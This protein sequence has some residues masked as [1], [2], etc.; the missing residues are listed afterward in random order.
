MNRANLT[1]HVTP[2]VMAYYTF[3]QGFRPGGFNRTDTSPGQ[4]PVQRAPY[5]G[6]ASSDPRCGSSGDLYH[7]DTFQYL[8]PVSWDSDKL[9]NNELGIKSEF[10]AHRVVLNASAFRMSWNNVQWSL[11]DQV[12][13]GSLGFVANGPSYAVKGVELQLV[14]R[15]TEG[16]TFEGSGSWNRSEQTNT[17]CV[18]SAGVTPGTPNNPTPAGQCITLIRGLPYTNPWG[19]LGSSLP[20]SPPLQF[21]VRAHYEWSAAAFRPF[22]MM[23][24][25]H[26]ASMRNTP[27][28][29]PD[30]NDPAQNPPTSAALKYTIPGYTSYDAALG[31]S[32]DNWTVQIQATNMTNAYGPTNISSAQFIKAEIPLRPRVLMFSMRYSF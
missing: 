17:P 19:P 1:W 14:A 13:F 2:D 15:V 18:H 21:N 31:V 30:G 4:H 29:Y 7:K 32:R 20:Y 28:N 22:A 8:T 11:S 10:L 5:C 9:I 16:L 12:N 24:A 25:S 23:S 6:S 3:S 27:E 26:I